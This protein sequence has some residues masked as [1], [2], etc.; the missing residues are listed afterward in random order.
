MIKKITCTTLS[1]LLLLTCIVS[2]NLYRQFS[3]NVSLT[4]PSLPLEIFSIPTQ[5]SSLGE[6][7][8]TQSQ[9]IIHDQVLVWLSEK[10][11]YRPQVIAT[12]KKIVVKAK[13]VQEKKVVS[14]DTY[15]VNA[16]E[17]FKHY[18]FEHDKKIQMINLSAYFESQNIGQKIIALRE[19]TKN[20][21]IAQAE[22][23]DDQANEEQDLLI[24]MMDEVSTQLASTEENP[25]LDI[26]T[27][28]PAE[29]NDLV[30]IDYSQENQATVITAGDFDQIQEP[31][32]EPLKREEREINNM[33]GDLANNKDI[34]ESV[35]L[36]IQRTMDESLTPTIAMN[37][38]KTPAA[39]KVQSDSV[40]ET[41]SS[42]SKR[43]MS[44]QKLNTQKISRNTINFYAVEINHSNPSSGV[45]NVEFHSDV[46]P[47]RLSDAGSGS[48]FLEEKLNGNSG[49][50]RGTFLS[51]GFVPT[52]MDLSIEPGSYEL[53]I[54]LLTSYELN[55][56]LEAENLSS[57][58]GLLLI[59][60]ASTTDNVE[61]DAYYEAKIYLN[62]NFKVVE[63]NEEYE[64]IL[65]S[66]VTA[67][68]VLIKQSNFRGEL[69]QKIV[70]VT[71]D[72]LYFE[73]GLFVESS[74]DVLS[75]ESINVLGRKN[76]VLDIY[77]SDIKVFNTTKQSQ[78][79]A[80]GKYEI[81][82]PI[83]SAGM[84]KY[85][86]MTHLRGS[87]FVGYSS[88]HELKIPSQEL[89]YHIIEAHGLRS[90][91]NTCMIQVNFKNQ[92]AQIE[93]FGE[94]NKG[95]MALISTYL[96]NDGVWS[97]EATELTEQMF[98]AGDERGAISLRVEYLDGSKD[99]LQTFCSYDTYLV[100]QL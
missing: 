15:T 51:G 1:S 82:Y 84:R 31:S 13:E 23:V 50:I 18:G 11:E 14:K 28:E 94:S 100:E 87:I 95:P 45:T 30:L 67:G 80:I 68:N 6:T 20:E 47:E 19:E 96:D 27:Q 72:E 43:T 74:K 37:T 26:A 12:K 59:Q 73:G 5:F 65:F 35:M 89:V 29:E 39:Q 4:L 66:G 76:S 8:E 57:H 99:Y 46:I 9:S 44:S 7:V 34:P 70:H 88:N 10:N 97:Q 42:T 91:E 92:V 63:P 36:A 90:L 49:S 81:A 71:D 17:R 83:Q 25:K 33:V 3:T 60:L 64:F 16:E 56:F 78:K 55:R 53:S 40:V 58:G 48:I 98:I 69:A 22:Y 2:I 86:E 79:L 41:K 77:S 32:S 93:A 85:L 62:N 54:P 75:L 52:K 21:V 38:Q 61:I 24:S